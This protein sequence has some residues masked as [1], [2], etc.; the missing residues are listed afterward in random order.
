[1]C[2]HCPGEDRQISKLGPV[3]S[4]ILKRG[5]EEGVLVRC[6]SQPRASRQVKGKLCGYLAEEQVE[7]P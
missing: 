1:M 5:R 4:R 3:L 6:E 7:M 2:F